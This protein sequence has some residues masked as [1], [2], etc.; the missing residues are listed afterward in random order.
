MFT[1][2]LIL[3]LG[4]GQQVDAQ[5]VATR[6]L[7]QLQN[8][9]AAA[10]VFSLSLNGAAVGTGEAQF[11]INREGQFRVSTTGSEEIFDG[12]YKYVRDIPKMTYQVFDSR[13]TGFPL[14]TPFEPIVQSKSIADR[15]VALFTGTGSPVVT[16][17]EG[18]NSVQMEFGSTKRYLN[19]ST[20]LPSGF[21]MSAGG[22]EYKGVFKQVTLE[23]RLGNNLVTFSSKP[24]ERQVPVVTNGLPKVGTSLP[25]GADKSLAGRFSNAILTVVVYTRASQAASNDAMI[26]L[27]DLARKSRPKLNVIAIN[28]ESQPA[29]QFFRGRRIPV[30]TILDSTG[31][32]QAAGVTQFPTMIVADREGKVVHAEA[33]G[34]E[35]TIKSVL[36]SN[37]YTF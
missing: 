9:N 11:A 24:G 5:E 37:G 19:P 31:L 18:A 32:T 23:P 35:G 15:T 17:F 22:V 26:A 3:A 12:R 21:T 4:T 8:A 27:G 36:Q 28:S 25:G 34:M 14:F 1:S 10:G 2:A 29:S 30:S 6:Y 33:G 13:S 20:A 7:R 16:Q